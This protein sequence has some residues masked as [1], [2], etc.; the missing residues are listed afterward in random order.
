MNHVVWGW[1][2]IYKSGLY[3]TSGKPGAY[4]RHGG[5]VYATLDA[6]ELAIHPRELYVTTLPLVWTEPELIQANP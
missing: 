5:D 1:V 4:D 6:A 3:H 2:N